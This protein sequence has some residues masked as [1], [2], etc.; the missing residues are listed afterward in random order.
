MIQRALLFGQILAGADFSR[1][2]AATLRADLIAYF[3]KEPAKQMKAY[4]SVAQWLQGLGLPGRKP[5]WLD[6]AIARYNEWES[7]GDTQRFREFQSYPFGKM[8]LK[9]NPVVVNSGGTIITKAHVDSLYHSNALVAE[10]AGLAPPAQAEKD[11]LIRSLPSRF[12]SLTK[13]QQEYLSRANGRMWGF[14]TI[15]SRYTGT[16]AAMIAD[17]RRNVHS[18]ADI[19]KEARRVENDC[20][21]NNGKYFVRSLLEGA[22]NVTTMSMGLEAIERSMRDMGKNGG[23]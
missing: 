7:Y 9:Y 1:A 16:R 6:L 13:E 17:I 20:V 12:G 19:P 15:Y 8:V 2:D 21:N 3:Q 14:A 5:S 10:A 18:S 4:E 11:Q 22:T 23:R